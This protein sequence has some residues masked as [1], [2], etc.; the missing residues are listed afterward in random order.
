MIPPVH[1][2]W[3]VVPWSRLTAEP[4]AH[5]GPTGAT[6]TIEGTVY[7]LVPT[8][9]A[10]WRSAHTRHGVEIHDHAR[11]VTY[12]ATVH[13]ARPTELDHLEVIAHGHVDDNAM[14]RVP[15]ERIRREVLNHLA[16]MAAAGPNALVLTLP[17]GLTEPSRPGE[18]PSPEELADRMTRHGWGR[19]ELATFYRRPVRTVDGWIRRA[20]QSH[21][22]L[23]PAPTQGARGNRK[24]NTK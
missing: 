3:S 11:N 13:P 8:I 15:V 1:T 2:S 17:G 12:R 22:H 20:R 21:P 7:D 19:Q 16:A 10:A 24:G 6:V 9:P 5:T 18:V 14:R 4:P 23:M